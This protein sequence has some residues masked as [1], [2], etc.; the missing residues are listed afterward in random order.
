[1]HEAFRIVLAILAASAL[2]ACRAGSSGGEAASAEQR[3]SADSAGQGAAAVAAVLAP[4]ETAARSAASRAVEELPPAERRAYY[5]ARSEAAAKALRVQRAALSR[6]EAN[7]QVNA[8]NSDRT[9]A[10]DVDA[11]I[12]RLRQRVAAQ[13]SRAQTFARNAEGRR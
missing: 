3:L 12:T 7:R 5:L 1:M 4:A 2:A 11:R 8:A 9:T 10:R 6:L 13:E